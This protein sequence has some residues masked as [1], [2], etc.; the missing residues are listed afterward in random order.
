MAGRETE[1]DRD[2]E[3][4]GIGR[5]IINPEEGVKGE[6]QALLHPHRLFRVLAL[7]LRAKAQEVDF[8]KN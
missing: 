7:L 2:R 8:Y 1:I 6:D 3:T 5:D 4:E